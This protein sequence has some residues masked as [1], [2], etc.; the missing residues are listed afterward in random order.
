MTNIHE[1]KPNSLPAYL[2]L[3]E[4]YQTDAE[5]SLWFRGC[6]RASYKLLPSLY[7]HKAAKTPNQFADLEQKLMARFRQRGMCQ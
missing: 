6:G 5:E 3:V 1:E 4:E 2:E 7:R